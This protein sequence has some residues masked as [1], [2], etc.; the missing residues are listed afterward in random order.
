MRKL[1]VLFTL[2]AALLVPAA[3]SSR[4]SD[5]V[6]PLFGLSTGFRGALLV[7]DAG[8]GPVGVSGGEANLRAELPGVTDV[9]V[10]SRSSLWALTSV[11]F[12]PNGSALWIVRHGHDPR[13]LVD[14]Q[15]FEN[16]H[17]PH[18]AT[19]ETDP[20]DV[21]DRG[22]GRAIVA[23]AAGNDV[24][25]VRRN[26]SAHLIAV[27][28]N[29]LVS[30]ANAKEIVGCPN[31]ENPD[32]Q[33]ICD[34]PDR[35]PAEPVATSVTPAPDGGIYVGELKGFP[36]PLH[37]SRVWHIDRGTTN[38][39]CGSDPRCQ[40]VFDDF[41]SV[42]DLRW[43]RGTLYVVQIDDRSWF[44]AE[45]GVG[46]GGSVWACDVHTRLCDKVV[47][48]KQWLTAITFRGGSMWGIVNAVIA[49][50]ADVVRFRGP[51]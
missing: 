10:R 46:V 2:V 28:P 21:L 6:S 18:P 35:I 42:I 43:F 50:Q 27:L 17:N 3:G 44:A 37:R 41:T 12:G 51:Q 14:L 25:R 33:E 26:G 40:I 9:S 48:G 16:Q 30:T 29:Q 11:A 23:D 34:L 45:A 4:P 39:H 15:E 8:Q 20:F 36:A 22:H 49:G 31:P 38:A 13:K 19:L 47:S 32:D 7:A 1:L 5:Y 24:I